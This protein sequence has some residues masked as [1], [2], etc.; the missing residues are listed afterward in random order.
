MTFS[1][2]LAYNFSQI[3]FPNRNLHSIFLIS[4]FFKN[5]FIILNSSTDFNPF[6]PVGD[7]Y[8]YSYAGLFFIYALWL[9]IF[10]KIEK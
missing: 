2:F 8:E 7:K 10:E 3:A 5:F 6:M 1:N 9:D 4:R